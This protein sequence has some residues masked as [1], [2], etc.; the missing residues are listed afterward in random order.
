MFWLTSRDTS[1]E[2]SLSPKLFH[3]AGST[4]P[5]VVALPTP[6]GSAPHSAGL[7]TAGGW[8]SGPTVQPVVAEAASAASARRASRRLTS[9]G[10][11]HAGA[12]MLLRLDHI[13]KPGID[14]RLDR[15]PS[16]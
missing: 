5:D 12:A 6:P 8:K 10:P 16:E 11:R 4:G 14:R 9:I 3:Q 1:E 7:A 15:E 2:S 13:R